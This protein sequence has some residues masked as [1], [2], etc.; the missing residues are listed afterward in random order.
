MN[1]KQ[2]LHGLVVHCSSE[3]F[4]TSSVLLPTIVLLNLLKRGK[5]IDE[6]LT[7]GIETLKTLR[8][9][10]LDTFALLLIS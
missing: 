6:N 8:T 5:Q 2:P 4:F 1:V 10:G 7:R 9:A 3:Y